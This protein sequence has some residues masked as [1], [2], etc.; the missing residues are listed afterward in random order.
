MTLVEN[1]ECPQSFC[2]DSDVFVVFFAHDFSNHVWI[3]NVE[4]AGDIIEVQYGIIP[5]RQ[6]VNSISF[7]LIPIGKLTPGQYQ[8]KFTQLPMDKQLIQEGFKSVSDESIARVICKP[9]AF[10]VTAK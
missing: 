4:R 5:Y 8:V 10:S 3:K 2:E 1:Q 9:F 6:K 7:A